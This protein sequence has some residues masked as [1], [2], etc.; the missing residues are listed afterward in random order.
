MNLTGEQERL[1][2]GFS[3]SSLIQRRGQF[4]DMEQA[5]KNSLPL[6]NELAIFQINSLKGHSTYFTYYVLFV[7]TKLHFSACENK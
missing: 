7:H 5:Q 4:I 3:L 6:I 1:I 2:S